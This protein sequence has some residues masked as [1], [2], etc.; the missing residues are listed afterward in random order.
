MNQNEQ[1][2]SVNTSESPIMPQQERTKAKKAFSRFALS[3]ILPLLGANI[4]ITVL[5]AVLTNLN[6]NGAIDESFAQS[7]T[8]NVLI[9]AI[10]L[11]VLGYPL[12]YILT[13]KAALTHS[14]EKAVQSITWN[15][16]FPDDPFG[17]VYR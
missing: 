16:V 12:I 5:G 10:P 8:I 17:H 15:H 4:V 1:T 3:I 13:K 6:M 7:S 11:L 2:V 14:R 9:G